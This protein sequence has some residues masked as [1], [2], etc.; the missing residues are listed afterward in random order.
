MLCEEL[1]PIEKFALVERV[2]PVPDERV[3]LFDSLML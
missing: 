3:P 1:W 2:K